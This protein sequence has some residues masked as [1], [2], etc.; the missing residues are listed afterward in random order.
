MDIIA[1]PKDPGPARLFAQK[2]L[3]VAMASDQGQTVD[4]GS[5]GSALLARA[6][7]TGP[8]RPGVAVL[9]LTPDQAVDLA[10]RAAN[11]RIV[12]ALTSE[13]APDLL[14]PLVQQA[15]APPDASKSYQQLGARLP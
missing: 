4:T 7:G 5:G 1:I 8:A 12:L 13:G 11:G 6:G 14:L 3:V 9:A 10:S 15:D 2:V